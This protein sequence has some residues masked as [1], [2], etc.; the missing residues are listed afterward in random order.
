MNQCERN[1]CEREKRG[2]I[3]ASVSARGEDKSG[4]VCV[5]GAGN[6]KAGMLFLE[7]GDFFFQ[8]VANG[9]GCR[10]YRGNGVL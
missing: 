8:V 3:S 5:R 9:V 7:L 2:K 6:K 10:A 1:Q 4:W